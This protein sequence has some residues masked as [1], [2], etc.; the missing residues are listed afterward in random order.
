MGSDHQT[1]ERDLT[2]RTTATHPWLAGGLGRGRGLIDWPAVPAL[3]DMLRSEIAAQLHELAT[4]CSDHGLRIEVRCPACAQ[5]GTTLRCAS[6]AA[7][8]TSTM[9]PMPPVS[10]LEAYDREFGDVDQPRPSLLRRTLN[11]LTGA[12]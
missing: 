12:T 9:P 2:G 3:R 8:D 11:R 10:V 4:P 7:G 6:I 5:Y 1:S